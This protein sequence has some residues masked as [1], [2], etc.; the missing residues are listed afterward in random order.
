MAL[1]QKDIKLLWGRAAS[2]CGICRR[3]LT[4]DKA[5]ATDAFPFGEQA[6]I[7]AEENGGPRGDSILTPEQRNGYHN[8]ILLCPNHHTIIDKDLVDYPVEKLHMLKAEHELWVERSLAEGRN[9]RADADAQ[10]LADVID[11]AVTMCRLEEWEIWTGWALSTDPEWPRELRRS[12]EEFRRKVMRV[13]WP[14]HAKELRAATIHLSILLERAADAF[15][16]FAAPDG[17]MYVTDRYYRRDDSTALYDQKAE[18]FRAQLSQSHE[19]IIEAS[20]AANWFADIVR[21]DINPMFLALRGRFTATE[22]PLIDPPL[23]F[24]TTV[25]EYT[26]EAIEALLARYSA[27]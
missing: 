7:V 3:Q 4:E 8:T 21:R 14:A 13:I 26:V 1:S 17:D 2:R 16:E 15:M 20:M 23:A 22:G 27:G 24:R 10:V 25:P 5:A 19:S 9:E 6:H 11:A 18:Q 12:I